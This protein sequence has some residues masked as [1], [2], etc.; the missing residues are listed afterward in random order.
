MTSMIGNHPHVAAPRSA[1][2]VLIDLDGTLVDSEPGIAA[3]FRAALEA[4]GHTPDPA[5]DI[6]AA[7]GPPIE[8]IARGLLSSYGD[9]RV[10]EA[11][12][13]YRDDYR[14]RGLLL[15]RPYPGVPET[16]VDLHEAGARLMLATSKRQTFARSILEN[17]GLDH[18]FAAIHGSEPGGGLDR[19][20]ELIAHIVERHGLSPDLCVMVGDRDLDVIGAHANGMRALGVL[21]G[22]GGRDELEAAGAQGLV[23]EPSDLANAVLTLAAP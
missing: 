12:A 4:L 22:Y 16:L 15:C 3:S 18:L 7:I 9:D 2:T 8:D 17:Q 19:K 6:T 1:P 21:W 10:A 13:A 23:A 20:P 5:L 11:V 14:K